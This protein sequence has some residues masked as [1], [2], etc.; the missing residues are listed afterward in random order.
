MFITYVEVKLGLLAMATIGAGLLALVM[1]VS[2]AHLLM[3]EIGRSVRRRRER[4]AA[5]P[6]SRK[7]EEQP[8][9]CAAA[10]D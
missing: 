1:L 8:R 7:R 4:R 3:R 2:G 5:A 10:G 9:L 6:L